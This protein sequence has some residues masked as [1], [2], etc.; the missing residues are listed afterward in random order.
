MFS[1]TDLIVAPATPPAAGARG[2]VR[3]AGDGL[4]EVL[5]A[6]L[7][8][9]PPGFARPGDRPRHVATRLAAA[10]LGR[11][12]GAFPVEVLHWPG[13]GGPLGMP[14]A[15]LQLPGSGPLLTAVVAAACREGC[16]LARGGEFSLRA[17]LAG[18]LDLVQAEAV[19]AV[20]DAG[21]PA[22]LA[23]ALDRMAA[24]AGGSLAAVRSDLLDLLADVEAAI[25]F[26]DETAPDGVPAGHAWA[27]WARRIDRACR[28]LTELLGRLADRSAAAAELPR[29]ALL[30]PP[31]IGKSSLFNALLGREAALVADEP[32]T[33]RDWLEARLEGGEGPACLVLDTAGLRPADGPAVNELAAA[34][35][36]GGREAIGRAAVAVVCRDAGGPAAEVDAVPAGVVRLD[37]VTRCDRVEAPPAGAAIATSSLTGAGIA[38]LRDAILAAVAGLPP[39]GSPATE[40]LAAGCEAAAGALAEAAGASRKAAAGA[41]VDE[42]IVAV[43]LR[44]AVDL[45]AEVTGS[46]IDTD[47][48]DRIFSR[49]CIGK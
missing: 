49:H 12:W 48:L 39:R 28:A 22:E 19:L 41:A 21:S 42:A 46:A 23:A 33:T 17:F 20:V 37:V 5:T 29:V 31:N 25:D 45:L 35:E 38:P 34:G 14:L 43:S 4:A 44:R 26:A 36:A 15:E 9:A 2:I 47:L 13:P 7:D 30:G 24:A 6:M 10:G 16:R 18:R 32:G 8:P 27:D 3:I 11:A 1:T 40:R